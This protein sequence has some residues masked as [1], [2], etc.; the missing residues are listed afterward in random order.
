MKAAA[1]KL[2]FVTEDECDSQ[3]FAS[4]LSLYRAIL[5]QD[6]GSLVNRQSLDGV[7]MAG[8]SCSSEDR[9]VDRFLGS[10]D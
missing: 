1:L 3:R 6:V 10:L 4:D 5:P 7:P 8:R 2:G 9:I